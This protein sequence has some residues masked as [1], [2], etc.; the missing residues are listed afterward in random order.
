M[1]EEEH[2]TNDAS[3]CEEEINTS[4]VDFKK[5]IEDICKNMFPNIELTDEQLE[6]F[7]KRFIENN[8][9]DDDENDE[10]DD[11]ED[12]YAESD[13]NNSNDDNEEESDDDS[14]DNSDEEYDF[15]DDEDDDDDDEDFDIKNL[16]LSC[17]YCGK[18]IDENSNYVITPCTHFLH[19][20]CVKNKILN[21]SLPV[22]PP[23]NE[24]ELD[25][26]L[27]KVADEVISNEC[28]EKCDICMKLF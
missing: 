5:M 6:L 12:S 22:I 8:D 13:D 3:N 16:C 21:N 20:E 18:V 26:L 7:T 15:D 19:T 24:Q 9:E 4:N 10:E 28:N 27:D 2:S 17:N 1:S 14:D 25:E 23:K 11:E